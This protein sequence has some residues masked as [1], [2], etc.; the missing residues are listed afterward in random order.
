VPLPF[1][2]RCSVNGKKRLVRGNHDLYKTSKYF[3]YFEEI[4]GSR[5]ING[6]WLTHIPMHPN[7]VERAKLNI[8]GHTHAF[9][10][11]DPKYFNASVEAINYTPIS[12]DTVLEKL[13]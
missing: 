3:E 12:I 8:H 9:C 5:Q 6:V 4:Y 2:R 11:D 13:P 10:L 7:S 1:F